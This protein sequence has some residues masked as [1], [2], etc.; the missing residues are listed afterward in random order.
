MNKLNAADWVA[1][2]L[3]IIGGINWGLVGFFNFNLVDSIFGEGSALARIIYALVGLS[4]L[5]LVPALLTKRAT[6]SH[7]GAT[8]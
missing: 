6:S 3:V 7:A 2:A 8:A 5:Y 1:L 4:A